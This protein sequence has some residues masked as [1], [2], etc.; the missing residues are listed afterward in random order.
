MAQVTDAA[1]KSQN[2][3]GA[4]IAL[5]DISSTGMSKYEEVSYHIPSS[6]LHFPL[7]SLTHSLSRPL[8]LYP[9]RVLSVNH[10]LTSVQ[11]LVPE[12]LI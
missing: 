4:L 5:F 6:C 2:I 9:P 7:S 1:Q 10:P 12:L 3:F 11:T 8:S